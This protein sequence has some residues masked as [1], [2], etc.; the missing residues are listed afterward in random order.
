MKTLTTLTIDDGRHGQD[1]A[2]AVVDDRVHRLV[3]NNVKVMLQV[4]V[5]LYESEEQQQVNTAPKVKLFF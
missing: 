2:I 3:L 5:C 1:D 4:A